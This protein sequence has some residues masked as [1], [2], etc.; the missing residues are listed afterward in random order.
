MEEGGGGC[1][2]AAVDVGV[3]TTGLAVGQQFLRSIPFVV[4]NANGV[5]A[6]ESVASVAPQ[7]VADRY[8]FGFSGAQSPENLSLVDGLSTSSPVFGVNG[9][10]LPVEFLEEA[11][12]LTGGY[13]AEFGRATGGVLSLI[14]KSG[15]N[16]FHGSTWGTWA[17]GVLSGASREV[18]GEQSML[19]NRERAWNTAGRAQPLVCRRRS[20]P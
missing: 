3:A 14:T 9:L 11:T 15:S 5:R 1:F 12:V 8:G 16:E 6:A 19:V 13:Q 10:Q 18:T 4:P 7:V 20:P 17:P 2:L